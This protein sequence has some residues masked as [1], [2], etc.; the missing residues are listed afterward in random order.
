MEK[1]IQSKSFMPFI[2][3]VNKLFRKDSFRTFC[4]KK[5]QRE[6]MIEASK[7]KLL[8]IYQFN[9]CSFYFEHGRPFECEQQNS[10]ESSIMSSQVVYCLIF[11]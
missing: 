6:W 11:L 5:G 4:P 1:S 8:T 3:T 9:E 2:G 7:R 10:F